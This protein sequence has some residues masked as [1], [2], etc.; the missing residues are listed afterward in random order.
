MPANRDSHIPE[1][2]RY[3]KQQLSK[4]RKWTAEMRRRYRENRKQRGTPYEQTQ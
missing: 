3:E 1:Y 2:E 4:L